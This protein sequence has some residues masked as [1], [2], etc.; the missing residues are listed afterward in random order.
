MR[1]GIWIWMWIWIG[2]RVG[3][4]EE[5]GKEKRAGYWRR[6]RDPGRFLDTSWTLPG[7]LLDTS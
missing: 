2:K 7:H 6:K 4:G 5:E 1:I 3:E